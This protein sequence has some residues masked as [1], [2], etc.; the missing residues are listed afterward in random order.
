MY[1]NEMIEDIFDRIQAMVETSDRL[2]IDQINYI[3]EAIGATKGLNKKDKDQ[4]V[5]SVH[6]YECGITRGAQTLKE[7]MIMADVHMD[8]K[9]HRT[10]VLIGD[11]ILF[12]CEP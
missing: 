12:A 7:G 4:S 1:K 8:A 6:C 2:T 9:D 5:V 3:T 10:A 11:T